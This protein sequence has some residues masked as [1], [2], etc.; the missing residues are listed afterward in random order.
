MTNY[1]T[2]AEFASPGATVYAMK[3]MRLGKIASLMKRSKLLSKYD[4]NQMSDGQR[5]IL[6][7]GMKMERDRIL[8]KLDKLPKDFTYNIN[9]IKDVI[10]NKEKK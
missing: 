5:E 6:F 10:K 7:T 1:I 2:G 4:I 8:G 9:L 3:C